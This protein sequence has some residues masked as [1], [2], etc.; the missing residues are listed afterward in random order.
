M[1]T[2]TTTY[3]PELPWIA[4]A[5]DGGYGRCL[6]LVYDFPD[7]GGC[8][9]GRVA[10]AQALARRLITVRGT[11]LDDPDY[12]YDLQDLLNGRTKARDLADASAA[13]IT[14]F[15]LDDRVR[16]AEVEVSFLGGVLLV[17]CTIY[18]GAGPFPLTLSVSDAA[19]TILKVE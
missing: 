5:N 4:G 12:G 10:L 8:V 15:R 9:A 6:S 3:K 11:L 13:I 19:I 14:Q 1:S 2:E 16:D 7:G 17:A 18:D